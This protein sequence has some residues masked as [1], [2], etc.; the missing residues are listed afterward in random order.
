M[1]LLLV[2]NGDS[3][4]SGPLGRPTLTL[5]LL[6]GVV[7]S[8]WV[9][10]RRGVSPLLITPALHGRPFP[11][12][13]CPLST[14]LHGVSALP[15]I[16][17]PD[18]CLLM[19]TSTASRITAPASCSIPSA[20]HVRCRC[21]RCAAGQCYRCG[22][23]AAQAQQKMAAYPIALAHL[24]AHQRAFSQ[25]SADTAGHG[26]FH[27]VS[28]PVLLRGPLEDAKCQRTLTPGTMQPHALAQGQ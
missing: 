28:L 17:L 11:V 13:L 24:T 10:L 8:R 21:K 4:S 20:P 9:S 2:A 14:C 26:F 18:P 12:A 22:T 6:Q 19:H 1:W 16:F 5:A 7:L 27:R 3:G 25:H 15:V 23:C